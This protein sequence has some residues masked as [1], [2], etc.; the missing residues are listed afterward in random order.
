M[1]K[2]CGKCKKLLPTS[3]FSPRG[4]DPNKFASYCKPCHRA[5][6]GARVGIN[7]VCPD[8]GITFFA[9]TKDQKVCSVFCRS[10]KR[11]QDGEN[12]P[13][14]KGVHISTRGYA[15]IRQPGHHRALKSGYVKRA[16]LVAEQMIGRPLRDDEVVHHKN[17]DRLDDSPH[18]LQVLTESEHM[19]LHARERK[20]AAQKKP[21]PEKAHKPA[22]AIKPAIRT[23]NWPSNEDLI[24]M[25][26]SST[27]RA[28]AKEIGCS[29]VA[30]YKRVK[31]F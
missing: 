17:H 9:K 31:K 16:D 15:Y 24:R 28:V 8:C 23:I 6:S 14:W 10:V 3:S 19:A 27:Y 5:C 20:A 12:N 2:T 21:K 1:M 25:V 7:K 30:V 11:N 22:K 13:N 4:G 18:N 26:S 29:H